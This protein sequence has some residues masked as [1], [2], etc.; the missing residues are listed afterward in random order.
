MA[1][2]YATYLVHCNTLST[3]LTK[4]DDSF[5][6]VDRPPIGQCLQKI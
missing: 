2:G 1:Y 3:L 4:C 5:G 6:Y